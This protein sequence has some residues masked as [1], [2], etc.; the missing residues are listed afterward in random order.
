[1]SYDALKGYLDDD[2]VETP[3]IPSR[4]HPQGRAYR[5]T[6]PDAATGIRLTAMVS[7]G[8]DM[9]LGAEIDPKDAERLKLDDAQERDFLREVLGT[10]YDQLVADGVSW[11]R[12]QRLGRYF[13]LYFTLGP[14]AAEA[15]ARQSS[16]EAPA[17]ANRE[18]RRAA[19]KT[20]SRGS[21]A[22]ARASRSRGSTAPTTSP[23]T[24]S[25]GSTRPG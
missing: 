18:Q 13:L 10:A 21:S 24:R 9:A 25:E 11:L 8:V 1:M 19:T 22:A 3:P 17:P 16:G 15:E 14:E 4:E 20:S 6:S 2:S 23:S 7:V 5:I 12:I